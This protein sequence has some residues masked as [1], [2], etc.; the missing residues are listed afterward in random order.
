MDP[1]TKPKGPKLFQLIKALFQVTVLFCIPG[2]I[3]TFFAP[4][5]TIE[6][7][8]VNPD[9]VDATVIK[10]LIFIL[11]VS[12]DTATNIVDVHSTTIDGG[13]IREGHRSTGKVVGK[14]EDEGLLLLKG[15]EDERIEVWVSPKNL[16][17]VWSEIEYFIKRGNEP[18]LKLWVVSNWKL[19]V[20]LPAGI[21]L[22]CL[23]IFFMAAWSIITGKSL[24]SKRSRA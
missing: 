1:K 8:R 5:F 14:V 16:F 13:V 2:L 12:T 15:A 6:L 21:M 9:R 19:G 18:S 17:E 7:S 10:K 24:E 11:P 20:F 23:I 22:V 4:S 3:T